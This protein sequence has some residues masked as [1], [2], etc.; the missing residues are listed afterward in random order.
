MVEMKSDETV[1]KVTNL[2]KIYRIGVKEQ[3][4]DSFTATLIDFLKGPFKNYRKY[5]SLYRFDDMDNETGNSVG[6]GNEDII[7]ALRDVSFN[8]KRGDV[9]GVIGEN[10]AGKSTLLKILCKITTP[11]K[12]R[13]EILGR[14][15]SL[16]EVGTGFHP[17]LTGRENVY[18]NG[19]ILGMSKSEIDSKF[20]EIID[21]SGIEKFIDTPV[22]RYSSGMGVRLAFSVAA[23]LEPEIL[24]VD[25]V[26][27]VGDASFQKK[28]IGKMKEVAE[29]GRT[30]LFVS[31]NFAAV[32]NL[33]TKAIRI[34]QG[35][36]VQKGSPREVIDRYL[37][38]DAKK[39]M[40]DIGHRTD[41]K[42]KGEIK[43]RKIELFNQHNEVVTNSISGQK[44]I[45][46]LHY[47]CYSDKVFRRCVMSVAVFRNQIPYFNLSTE[48][49]DKKELRLS[50][51]GYLDFIIPS[52][53]L[54]QSIY[55]LY[56]YL[57]SN[58][59]IQDWILSAMELSVVDG[60]Y[61]G[62]GK[63]Y[64]KAWQG[65]GVLVKHNW[66]LNDTGSSFGVNCS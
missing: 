22:K 6:N 59:E 9:L 50:G 21:F 33:C 40:I 38:E 58:K 16:L 2:S 52:L 32:E 54:S 35:K 8:V 4:K 53:P 20:D 48:L 7:W 29:V 31:H 18:L 64:P 11:T 39:S 17:E 51:E 57:E 60:D 26:L 46:R 3:I 10:G 65:V 30:V 56:T 45:I 19:T 28:C 1:I 12:G 66:K 47:K 34:K 25:E 13:A 49:V 14:V 41:R 62:T 36:L 44:L 42:G 61:Y 27:A 37:E 24:L 15:S 23:H 5:R 43:I 55:Y 63:N